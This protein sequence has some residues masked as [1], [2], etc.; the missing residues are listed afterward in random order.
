MLVFWRNGRRS[1]LAPEWTNLWRGIVGVA[2][3]G[4]GAVATKLLVD[5]LSGWASADY[6]TEPGMLGYTLM[7][8]SSAVADALVVI[9]AVLEPLCSMSKLVAR[10]VP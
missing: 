4:A 8:G 10:V 6:S 2:V 3:L 1:G 9:S 5:V 7:A